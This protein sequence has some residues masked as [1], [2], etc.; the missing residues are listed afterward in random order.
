MSYWSE[1]K[2]KDPR[3]ITPV[4]SKGEP[5][6]HHEWYFVG[7]INNDNNGELYWK[8][9]FEGD[10]KISLWWDSSGYEFYFNI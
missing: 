3:S 9:T 1:F 10:T 5:W 6:G 4:N 8:G 2:G 7:S